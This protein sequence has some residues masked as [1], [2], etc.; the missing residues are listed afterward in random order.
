MDASLSLLVGAASDPPIHTQT[1][2]QRAS[3]RPPHPRF[4]CLQCHS[5]K[6]HG[7]FSI[8]F[9]FMC[10]GRPTS[11]TVYNAHPPNRFYCR[12]VT[13]HKFDSFCVCVC[14]SLCMCV[15]VC[16][17]FVFSIRAPCVLDLVKW[18]AL[19]FG[20]DQETKQQTAISQALI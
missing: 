2:R 19:R 7:E 4:G 5:H 20:I 18:H 8:R 16:A 12:P 10:G 17:F 13:C 9:A 14:A 3:R 6:S 15:C 11:R 1:H